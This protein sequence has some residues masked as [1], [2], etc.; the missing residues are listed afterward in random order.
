MGLSRKQFLEDEIERLC[1][2]GEFSDELLEYMSELEDIDNNPGGYEDTYISESEDNT[3]E[4]ELLLNTDELLEQL[5]NEFSVRVSNNKPDYLRVEYIY[6]RGNDLGL[7]LDDIHHAIK[8][9]IADSRKR[10]DCYVLPK[11]GFKGYDLTQ[12]VWDNIKKEVIVFDNK[13]LH[14]NLGDWEGPFQT[15]LLNQWGEVGFRF[16]VTR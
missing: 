11:G 1:N 4:D 8:L 14:F 9:I 16:V 3:E 12:T 10:Y 7:T 2:L 6:S 5:V 13:P 15:S